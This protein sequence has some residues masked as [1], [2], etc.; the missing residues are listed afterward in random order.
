MAA[1]RSLKSLRAA[2]AETK[3]IA[4]RFGLNTSLRGRTAM[5]SGARRM[6]PA[7]GELSFETSITARVASNFPL[8]RIS[9]PAKC[10]FRRPKRLFGFDGPSTTPRIKGI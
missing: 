10:R 4:S 5:S 9:G 1:A 6:P 2:D 8:P 3:G 7:G